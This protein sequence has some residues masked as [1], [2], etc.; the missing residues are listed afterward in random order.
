[1]TNLRDY[2]REQ[3]IARDEAIER[4]SDAP[5]NMH[6]ELVE[7]ALAELAKHPPG[8]LFTVLDVVPAEARAKIDPDEPR[9]LGGVMTTLRSR[10]L[11]EVTAHPPR[12]TGSHR[13]PQ[14]VWVKL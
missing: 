5:Q 6:P 7:V 10:K 12:R 8:W 3:T 13:R 4:V 9:V 2:L 11:A 1:M 14:T